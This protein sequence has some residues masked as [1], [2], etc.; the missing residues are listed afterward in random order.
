MASR[1]MLFS[2]YMTAVLLI[3]LL[4][5]G[6]SLFAQHVSTQKTHVVSLE[7]LQARITQAHDT[8][9]VINFWA[10]WCKPCVQELPAFEKLRAEYTSGNTRPHTPIKVLLVSVNNPKELRL[11]EAF[12]SKHKYRS[13]S[14]LLSA[15]NPNVWINAIDSSWSGAVPATMIV[16]TTQ[17]GTVARRLFHEG[18]LTYQELETMV[19]KILSPLSQKP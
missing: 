11:V 9:V 16:R 15:G 2:A 6:H 13:E 10:T 4:L 8:A 18:E 19:E 3:T 1:F 12:M 17:Q 7:Q 14:L 5:C